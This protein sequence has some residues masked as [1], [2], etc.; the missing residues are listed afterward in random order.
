MKARILL[1]NPPISEKQLV[2]SDNYFPL[3]LLYLA[4]YL[5]KN[6]I[7]VK[8]VDI[9][10]YYFGK[11]VDET[12]LLRYIENNLLNFIDEFNPDM[13]GIGCTFSGAFKNLRLVAKQIKKYNPKIPIIV[14]GVQPTLFAKEILKKYSYIDY[15]I[16]GE[17]EISFLNLIKSLMNGEFPNSVNGCVFK[18]EENIIFNSKTNY[19]N[20]LN[21]LPQVDYNLL[22]PKEYQ[23]DTSNWYSPKKIL[24]GQPFPILSSRSCPFSCTF[25]CMKLIHGPNIRFRSPE[26]VL[27]EIEYLYNNFNVRY[28]QFMDDNLTLNK[29]RISKIC[30]GILNRNLDIQFDT[31]NGLSLNALDEEIITLMVDAGLVRTSLAIE[32]GSEYIRNNIM[33]KKL[34]TEKIYENVNACAEHDNL[35]IKGFFIVGM[36]QETYETLDETYQMIKELPFDKIGISYIDPYPGTELFDYCISHDLLSCNIEDYIEVGTFQL[37]DEYPHIKPYKLEMEDL[38]VFKKKCYDFIIEKRKISGLPSNY[39]LRWKPIS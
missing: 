38:I 30:K 26:N 14:G 12:I 36:P 8:I 39:P 18:E 19:I 2:G 3:G 24:I 1:T 7:E 31:P 22:N 33:K 16:I 25:C 15:V 20:D 5:K 4:T 27:D 21:S 6:D 29:K 9:N 32:S 17:G 34:S 13:I 11:K 23:M 28:F 10:N 37:S 35:F